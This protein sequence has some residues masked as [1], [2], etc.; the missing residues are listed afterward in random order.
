MGLN[1][2]PI[3]YREHDVN[4]WLLLA[5][6]KSYGF[7]DLVKDKKT[8]W[9]GISGSLAQKHMRSFKAGDKVLIYHTAPD[10]AVVG[11][12]RIVSDPYPDPKDHEQ[13]MVVVDVERGAGFKQPVPLAS[14]RENHKLSAMTFLKIQ[15]IAVSPISKA[16]WDE[17]VRMGR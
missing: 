6:P 15:R 3:N 11:T 17:I 16:E 2:C 1:S 8:V 13:K 5:D 4:H 9:D 12:A 10:K 7:E 14:M